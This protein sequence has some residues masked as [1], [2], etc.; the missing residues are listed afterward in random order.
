MLNRFPLGQRAALH[1]GWCKLNAGFSVRNYYG[2]A[3]KAIGRGGEAS[4]HDP[5]SSPDIL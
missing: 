4:T 2:A 1:L 3:L 5:Q